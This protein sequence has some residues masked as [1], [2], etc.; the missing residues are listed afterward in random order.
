MTEQEAMHELVCI[1]QCADYGTPL[2][3]NQGQA[4]DGYS[5]LANYRNVIERFIKDNE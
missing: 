2:T 4:L 3:S 5:E 1:K